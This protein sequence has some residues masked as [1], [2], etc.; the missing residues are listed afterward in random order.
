MV[1]KVRAGYTH[2]R[3]FAAARRLRPPFPG[4]MA[5]R[6]VLTAAQMREELDEIGVDIGILFPDHLLTL[7]L[8]PNRDY[9][10]AL[11]R[12]YNAWLL[13]CWL[14]DNN[15]L[16]GALVAAPQDPIDAARQIE[17]Y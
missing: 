9:A 7:A 15:G 3:V 6:K 1:K 4:G 11:A 5:A 16:K 10:A 2:I 8:L 17:R 12:A 13:D 14:R